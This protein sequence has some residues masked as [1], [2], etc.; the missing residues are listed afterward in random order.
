MFVA[1]LTELNQMTILLDMPV[2]VSV[3][4]CGLLAIVCV[5][6][7]FLIGRRIPGKFKARINELEKEM[8]KNHAEILQLQKE[9]CSLKQAQHDTSDVA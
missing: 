5:F 9:N 8:V 4:V 7:G 2:S 3:P 1:Y 6:L